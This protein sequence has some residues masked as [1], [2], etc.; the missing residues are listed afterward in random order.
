VPWSVPSLPL[1]ATPAAELREGGQHH[2]LAARGVAER[3]EEP[4]DAGVELA[5]QALLG[6]LLVGVG[7]EAAEAHVVDPGRHARLDH[8]GDHV[9]LV[10]QLAATP[11]ALATRGPV[12]GGEAWHRRQLDPALA[13][14]ALQHRAGLLALAD[15]GQHR[16]EPR[17][18]RQQVLAGLGDPRGQRR[19]AGVGR[20]DAAER[21]PLAAGGDR[22]RPQRHRGAGGPLPRQQQRQGGADGHRAQRVGAGGVEPAAE[23]AGVRRALRRAGLPD[24]RRAEV[25]AVGLGVA[26]ALD[27]R[28]AVVAPELGEAL[29]AGVEAEVVVEPQHVAGLV[30]EL[31]RA[32]W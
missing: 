18:V 29:E 12:A 23:P 17:R 14:A 27:D 26:D 30:G 7:V 3:L 32:S 15:A 25:A 10:G 6:A 20:L 31:G 2:P 9:E 13:A 24:V 22:Q 5:E 1:A 8:A 19:A 28:Q 4:R 21:L 11:D 16:L